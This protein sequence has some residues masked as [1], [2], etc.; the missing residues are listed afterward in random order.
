MIYARL[1]LGAFIVLA[2]IY[3]VMVIGQL[4]GA[5][6]ITQRPITFAKLCMPFYYW[7]VSQKINKPTNKT[8]NHND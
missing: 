8:S 7:M 3:Y 6:K 5:W 4:F 1:L 2:L